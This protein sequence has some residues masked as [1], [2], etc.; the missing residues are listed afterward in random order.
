MCEK[1]EQEQQ[2]TCFPSPILDDE[3]VLV[4]NKDIVDA[5][6]ANMNRIDKDVLRCDR[7]YPYFM[8]KD[9]LDKLKNVIYT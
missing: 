1:Q 7:N 9:N 2:S 3:D 4:N 5:F 6:A 8:C